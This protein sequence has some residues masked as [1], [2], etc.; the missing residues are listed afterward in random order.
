MMNKSSD[1]QESGNQATVCASV[2][3]SGHAERVAS[4]LAEIDLL[5]NRTAAPSPD[6]LSRAREY[7]LWAPVHYLG[8]IVTAKDDGDDVAIYLNWEGWLLVKLMRSAVIIIE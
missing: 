4:G 7:I 5:A 6:I 2:G 1:G 3:P 8:A